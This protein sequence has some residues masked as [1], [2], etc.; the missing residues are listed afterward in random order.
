[1]FH[2]PFLQVIK[3]AIHTSSEMEHIVGRMA[4]RQKIASINGLQL[5]DK[6]KVLDVSE[7]EVGHSSGSSLVIVG[8]ASV[9]IPWSEEEFLEQAVRLKHSLDWEVLLPPKIAEVLSHIAL[10]APLTS[11]AK[12][13]NS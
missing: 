5:G 3:L 9:G 4:K 12:G 13:S 7:A 11:N 10:R 6:T 8:Y 2:F 1:M